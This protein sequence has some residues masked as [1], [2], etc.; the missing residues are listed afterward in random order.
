MAKKCQLFKQ[1]VCYLGRIVAADGYRLDPEN[2]QSVTELVK[3]KP[4]T[5][6][7]VKRLLG[8]V[9]YFR[10]YIANISKK[11][12]PL[13]KLQKKT[14]DSKNSSKSSVIWKQQL[15]LSLI[16][17]P[18]LGY[19]DYTLEFIIH[20]DASAKGL[21][22]VLLQYQENELKVIG[23]G[24]QPLTSVEK[25]YHSSKLEFLA[26]KWAAFHHF[27]DY[28]CYAPHFKIYT[29]GRLSGTGQGWINKLTEFNFSIHYS[30]GKRNVIAYILSR[31]SA[32]TFVEC[33]KACTKVILSD[34]VKAI[35]DAASRIP[36]PAIRYVVSLSELNNA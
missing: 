19:P 36:T 12:A 13:Y 27:Q 2:I 6:G 15:L 25:K 31:P 14:T 23:Y 28:M 11:A 5:L 35:L 22:A 3:Q 26:V 34:Q 18:I 16:E 32:N 17:P 7:E 33:M 21:R 24:S 29:T 8:M 9:C 10:K 1:E 20:V 4:K 30:L